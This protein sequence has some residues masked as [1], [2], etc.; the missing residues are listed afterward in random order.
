M[1]RQNEQQ[2]AQQHTR[3]RSADLFRLEETEMSG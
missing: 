1:A 2:L 3:P